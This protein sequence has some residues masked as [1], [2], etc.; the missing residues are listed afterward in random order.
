MVDTPSRWVAR[1]VP[2]PG[3]DVETLLAVGLGLD[4][5]ERHGNELVVAATDA[6]LA[7]VQRR[8]LATVER[9]STVEAFEKRPPAAGTSDHEEQQ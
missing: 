1:L 7:E 2:S 5:W 8:R 9:I 4:V 3:T 6:Q